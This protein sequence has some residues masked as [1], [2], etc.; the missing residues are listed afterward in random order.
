MSFLR[1]GK[2]AR[3]REER[4]AEGHFAVGVI[5]YSIEDGPS[6]VQGGQ[7]LRL[8]RGAARAPDDHAQRRPHPRVRHRPALDRT[9]PP[10]GRRRPTGW[11][12][13][14]ATCS[15]SAVRRR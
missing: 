13:E 2:Q 9:P 6:E 5:E 8:N 11:A 3:L 10:R 14:P 4:F 12:L 7:R 15:G 1:P